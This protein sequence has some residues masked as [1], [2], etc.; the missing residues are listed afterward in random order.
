MESNSEISKDEK[1]V[2]SRE[3]PIISSNLNHETK[4]IVEVMPKFERSPLALSPVI[5][6]KIYVKQEV[7]PKP[8]A[9]FKEEYFYFRYKD[10]P[11]YME[12][13]DGI[14]VIKLHGFIMRQE[15]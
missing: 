15:S 5:G 1:K 6:K 12:N 2:I 11:E 3:E 8:P 9:G 7:M 10:Y 13:G 4:S 14:L